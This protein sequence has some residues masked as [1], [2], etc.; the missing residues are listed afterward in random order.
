MASDR[1]L[2]GTVA[3]STMPPKPLLKGESFKRI[4]IL[5][6]YGVMIALCGKSNSVR[7]YDLALLRKV[8]ECVFQPDGSAPSKAA[9]SEIDQYLKKSFF[10]F[11]WLDSYF[12][13]FC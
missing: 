9:V 1:G 2:Y 4:D 3:G 10:F 6:E 13:Y 11:S 5:E 7:V 12:E 8:I